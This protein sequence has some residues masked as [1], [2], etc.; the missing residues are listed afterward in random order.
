MEFTPRLEV[1]SNASVPAFAP[2]VVLQYS[3]IFDSD[4]MLTGLCASCCPKCLIDG[5]VY[6][7]NRCFRLQAPWLYFPN[8]EGKYRACIRRGGEPDCDSGSVTR[9]PYRARYEF[10]ATEFVASCISNCAR[11]S[12][13]AKETTY[14]K[15]VKVKKSACKCVSNSE[16]G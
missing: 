10:V 11:L 14:A 7:R 1:A 13:A 16:P 4:A 8:R 3:Q 9:K 6:S 2:V 12:L 15:N 5:G